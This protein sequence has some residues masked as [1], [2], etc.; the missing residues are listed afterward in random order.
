MITRVFLAARRADMMTEACLDHWRGH[1]AAIGATLPKVRSY[2]QNHGV[3]DGGRFLLPYPG[4]DIMPE[5]D[6]DSL[7][8]MDAAIE[9]PAHEQDSIDDE[10][11]FIDTTRTGLLV[12][13]RQVLVDVPPPPDG[14]KLITFFRRAPSASDSSLHQA[15]TGDYTK[16]VAGSTAGRHEVLLTIPDRAGRAPFTAQAIDM[17]W[18]ETPRDALAWTMSDTYHRALWPLSGI[19]F[20]S[21]RLIARPNKVV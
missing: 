7:E 11:N 13:N 15:L 10:A 8:D 1:H 4:F 5:L 14:V 12:G 20:G 18:F 6:W 3:L 21:E 16:A 2:V 9:S 17:Q 19:A